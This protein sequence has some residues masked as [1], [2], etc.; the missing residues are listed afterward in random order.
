M[1]KPV[2]KETK[3][4]QHL[5]TGAELD[6]DDQHTSQDAQARMCLL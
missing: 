6:Q 3:I 4:L 1:L 5:P 2:C